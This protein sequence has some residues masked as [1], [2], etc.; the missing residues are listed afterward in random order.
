MKV[1]KIIIIVSIVLIVVAGIM[2]FKTF[3]DAGEFREIRPHFAGRITV[4]KGV[5]SSEDITIHPLTG[6]AFISSDDRRLRF[7]SDKGR[8]GAIFGYPITSDF[9]R[10]VNL[11]EGFQKPFHPVGIG[12]YNSRKGT[13]SLFVVN[14]TREGQFVEIFDF[15]GRRLVHRESVSGSLMSS[16]ND[17][18]PVGPRKFYVTNDHGNQSKLGRA[19]EE[20]LQLARSNVL[21]YDGSHFRKVAGG[22][23]YAN[24]INRSPDGRRVYVASTIGHKITVYD[25]DPRTGSLH[26]RRAVELA[27]GP[28]NIEVDE[29]G[30]L[31]VGAHPKLLTF[32]KYSKDPDRLSPSQVLRVTLRGPGHDRVEEVYLN[33]GSPLSGS[34]VAAY[35]DRV[36]LIGS[37]FD[38]RFLTCKMN[39]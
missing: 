13:V 28:D 9:P 19:L 37:V 32:V 2:G 6:M 5:Q 11:T 16:P 23:K 14:H 25:R 36:L 15:N 38:P 30:R 1:F 7:Q 22:L 18:L 39:E 26:F 8:Q 3:R 34:S 21:Y 10:I 4:V 24:G 33:N 20:Y 12:L 31:W 29:E 35:F 17:V 27:T